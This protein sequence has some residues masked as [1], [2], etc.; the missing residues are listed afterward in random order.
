ME[1]KREK[2]LDTKQRQIQFLR[3]CESTTNPKVARN[4]SLLDTGHDGE[5][6]GDIDRKII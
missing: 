1:R 2:P 5:L 3:Q 4:T 6:S